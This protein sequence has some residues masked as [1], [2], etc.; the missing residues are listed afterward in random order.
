M[1]CLASAV[2]ACTTPPATPE[3]TPVSEAEP[4]TAQ[5]DKDVFETLLGNHEL[6]RR[7]VKQLPNG[8]EA[9]T[10]SDNAE[11]AALIQN[12]VRAMKVRLEKDARIRQWDPI[13]VAIFDNAGKIRMEIVETP[14]G[15]RVQETSDDPWVAKLIQSHA[16]MVSGF[17]S[18]GSEESVLEHQAP[19]K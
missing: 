9:S 6:I 7:E 1:A 15:V 18:R 2:A 19:A 8:I 5:Y 12:H 17:V 11:V 10:E 16:V 13:F 14:K 4:G 3:P